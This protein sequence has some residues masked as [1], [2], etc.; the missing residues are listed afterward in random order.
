MAPGYYPDGDGLYLQVSGSGSKS[1]IYRYTLAGKSREMGLGSL[2]VLSLAD[3]RDRRDEWRRLKASGV[4]PI[5]A[6]RQQQAAERVRVAKS[7]TFRQAADK[8][9][10][11]HRA[12]WKNEVHAAQWPSTLERYAY[13]KLGDLPVSEIDTAL[14]VEVLE[15]IWTTKPETANRLRGRIEAILDAAKALGQRDGENPARWRGHLKLLMAKRP[16]VRRHH[17]ALP[18]ADMPEFMDE[19][20]RL[21]DLAARAL[22]FTILTSARTT[23]TLKARPEEFDL[24]ARLWTVPAERMKAGRVHRVP[25]GDRAVEILEALA[26]ART[27]T[28]PYVFPGRRADAQLS[29]MAMAKVLERMKRSVTVHGF[30]STFKDW[31]RERTN[32]ANEVSEAA[33]AHVIGDETQEAYARGDLFDKRRKLMMA[34]ERYCTEAKKISAVIAIRA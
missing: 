14:V 19:L 25:L 29:N 28:K 32:F 20:R 24:Q 27:G 26:P 16:R 3:A 31:A 10:A 11:A 4:D 21:E 34:W 13:P 7:V 23:E 30:R 9:I 12:D 5:E 2:A 1:W 22:E 17:A 18:Y 15:P 6:R 33:L 8:Y